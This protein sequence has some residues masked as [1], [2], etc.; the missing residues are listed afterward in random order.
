MDDLLN[1]E[2]EKQSYGMMWSNELE[3]VDKWVK[4]SSE[5][6]TPS[7]CSVISQSISLSIA[8]NDV[9]STFVIAAVFGFTCAIGF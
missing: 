1:D 8:A 4:P 9:L 7:S 3:L 5:S 6:E 2:S